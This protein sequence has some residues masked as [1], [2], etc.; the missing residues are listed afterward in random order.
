M[1]FRRKFSFIFAA[2]TGFAALLVLLLSLL[3]RST[4]EAGK[5]E[6]LAGELSRSAFDLS[7]VCQDYLLT[8]ERRPLS[9]LQLKYEQSFKLSRDPRLDLGQYR[10]IRDGLA[11]ELSRME[12]L[13]QQITKIDSLAGDEGA[14]NRERELIER[15]ARQMTASINEFSA[16]ARRLDDRST[17]RE[18][19]LVR[20]TS[21]LTVTALLLFLGVAGCGA[22]FFSRALLLRLQVVHRGLKEVEERNFSFRYTCHGTDE[23]DAVSLSFNRMIDSLEHLAAEQE[24][25]A[26][27]L[28]QEIAGRERAED[29]LRILNSELEERIFLRTNELMSSEL[30]YRMLAEKSADVIWQLDVATGRFVYV[31]PSVMQL[32]GYTPEEVMAEPMAAAL[33]PESAARVRALMRQRIAALEAGEVSP[34]EYLTTEVEQPCKGGSS[35]WTEVTT[36][37][38]LDVTGK[39]SSVI[40]ISRNITKRREEALQRDRLLSILEATRNELYVFDPETLHFIYVN[41]SAL[42]NLGFSMHELNGMTP[43]DLKPD[44]TPERFSEQ[45]APLRS[46]FSSVARFETV[47]KRADGT[48]YPVEVC[49]QLVK[50]RSSGGSSFFLAVINDM[51]E[52]QQFVQQLESAAR[53]WQT[54]FD[55]ITDSV[56]ML[57]RGQRII[58]CNLATST[59]LG[60]DISEI[61][62]HPCYSIFHGADEP[63]IDCPMQAVLSSR[64]SESRQF[65]LGSRWLHVTVHPVFAADGSVSAA[66]H[67]VREVTDDVAL[68]ER[69]VKSEAL[70]R[71]TAQAARM[72]GWEIDLLTSQHTWTDET[73]RIHEV[74]AGFV[75]DMAKALAFYAPESRPIIS[76]AVDRALASG[77][78]FD[79]ELYVITAKGRKRLVH[80]VGKAE[81]VDGTAVKLSGT[82]QDIHDQREAAIALQTMQTQMIQQEKLASIG[83][84][85]AGVAHEINNPVGFVKS[86]LSSLEK[87]IRKIFEYQHRIE[88]E[89]KPYL[90][91]AAHAEL[92]TLARSLKIE[93]IR[94][95]LPDLLHESI[96]GLNR[97]QKI[98]YD[99]VTYARKGSENLQ[100]VNLNDVINQTIGVA[101][102]EIK[103]RAE[104][105][106]DLRELPNVMANSQKLQQV[107]LNLIMNALHALPE[108]GGRIE[109]ATRLEGDY[110]CISI[111]DN[112]HGIPEKIRTRIFDPFFTT[113]DPGKGTGLGLSISNEIITGFG[114]MIKVA[115]ETG[116]GTTFT[117]SLPV[118]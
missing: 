25:Y 27:A 59:L 77:E 61:I 17:A 57:D 47:H 62:G 118:G 85:A 98:V 109:V 110:V 69:L 95:D 36:R 83:Q 78:P 40:G 53:E 73:C 4:S 64:R 21:V 54:T 28:K 79:L 93:F 1:T 50:A 116:K 55:S 37:Y 45:L 11:F 31:S 104:L 92:E 20:T 13:L 96:E 66:V 84:L 14:L 49:L 26:R 29:D 75:P 43:L 115:S 68:N 7:I 65:K 8:L 112:G 111:A 38:L 12:R 44:Y 19:H 80:A 117:V 9:Q 89:A 46:G 67:V 6:Q 91:K 76:A 41:N 71:Q 16:L 3:F 94:K 99:L 90:P 35:V 56:A 97:V 5:M 63:I 108:L 102:N 18:E 10:D 103:H 101:W 106:C 81:F 48:T 34:D 52:R 39:V 113:K 70:L 24:E 30:R 107:F 15:L 100:P 32:R 58:R 114:G 74:D 2:M 23:F 22:F 33:T 72:G 42:M 87:Y 105:I 82:L 60:R 51:T 86:N 88:T